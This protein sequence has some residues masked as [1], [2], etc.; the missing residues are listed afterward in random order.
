[1]FFLPLMQK[2]TKGC[3]KILLLWVDSIAFL[4]WLS[5]MHQE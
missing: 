1:M 5:T 2:E 3:W 4:I